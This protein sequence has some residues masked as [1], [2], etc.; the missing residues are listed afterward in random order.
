MQQKFIEKYSF[1]KLF[2][3]REGIQLIGRRWVN[4]FLLTGILFL[5]FLSIG[6]S[7]GGMEYLEKKMDDPFTNWLQLE[8]S[9]KIFKKIPEIQYQLGN[10]SLRESFEIEAVENY[11]IEAIGFEKQ[12]SQIF[13]FGMTIE[14]SSPLL[15]AILNR[16]GN[17]LS[18]A[19]L[20]E[21]ETL[22]EEYEDRI[23]VTQ[24][25]LQRLGIDSED[26][27]SKIGLIFPLNSK[28]YLSYMGILAVVD[29]L[30]GNAEFLVF[31][32][33][34]ERY[35]RSSNFINVNEWFL[36]FLSSSKGM[37]LNA[38]PS[39]IKASNWNLEKI[40]QAWYNNQWFTEYRLNLGQEYDETGLD[41]IWD[42]LNR[43]APSKIFFRR[44]YPT[45]IPIGYSND[46][47]GDYLSVSFG[48]LNAVRSFQNWM[49]GHY[50]VR[51]DMTQIETKENFAF[52]SLL[53]LILSFGLIIFSLLSII[54]FVSNMLKSHLERIK[55]NL[56]TFK[57][58]GL[59]NRQLVRIYCWISLIAVFAASFAGLILAYII[60]LTGIF[61]GIIHS[62]LPGFEKGIRL[63]SI[64]NLGILL[65]LV[66]ILLTSYLAASVSAKKILKATPGDLI[67][68][69]EKT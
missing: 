44:T 3:L 27:I 42:L 28:E 55:T 7:I 47:T 61:E 13:A 17:V 64:L 68:N 21:K 18:G 24:D 22:N 5:T 19:A 35:Q 12:G 16:E 41:S 46:Q 60:S 36:S 48:R 29:Q 15:N 26:S 6:F 37:D 9:S 51:T 25:L 40:G 10:D 31:P 11:S 23:V 4:L 50:Q 20:D 39:T 58:F 54:L 32:G 66:A 45:N 8:I 52:T 1:N 56:G 33:F 2:L 43:T 65:A 57:A 62:A 30:P 34:S 59:G 14:P 38:I 49:Q 53:T 67:Y 69:R 63:I